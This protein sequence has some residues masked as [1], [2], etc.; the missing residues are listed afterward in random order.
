MQFFVDSETG[1]CN[2]IETNGRFWASTQGTINAGWDVPW[3]FY[4]AFTDGNRPEVPPIQPGSRTVYHK[5]DF[6]QL[7]KHLV[8]G[9]AH[10]SGYTGRLGA[11]WHTLREFAPGVQSD[12][13]MWSDLKPA[14]YDY[15]QLFSVSNL[16]ALIRQRTSRYYISLRFSSSAAILEG[17]SSSRMSLTTGSRSVIRLWCITFLTSSREVGGAEKMDRPMPSNKRV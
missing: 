9:P 12:V 2:Y 16:R 8:L 6:E 17:S 1:D 4:R 13:W 14:L 15:W 7:F 10:A 5:G 3:W 11:I